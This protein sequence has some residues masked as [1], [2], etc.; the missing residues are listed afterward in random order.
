[1]LLDIFTARNCYEKTSSML[2]S[3]PEAVPQRARH[4]PETYRG[5]NLFFLM[6]AIGAPAALLY[7]RVVFGYVTSE[8]QV[9]RT[10]LQ[11]LSWSSN[12][13]LA[14][15]FIIQTISARYVQRLLKPRISRA[16]IALQYVAVLLLCTLLSVTGAV[17]LEGFGYT[18]F[19]HVRNARH[20]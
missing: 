17:L 19:L 20:V 18:F 12:I 2:T 1:M 6:L 10:Q 4:D 15:F 13:V 7:L 16:A 11:W 3:H 9:P 8:S 14:L 5:R